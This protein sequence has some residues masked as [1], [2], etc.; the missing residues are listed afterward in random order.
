MVLVVQEGKKD[1]FAMKYGKCTVLNETECENC[2]FYKTK[3]Q[4]KAEA[5]KQKRG[6]ENVE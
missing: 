1:C 5:K 4:F 6:N 2:K 3:E